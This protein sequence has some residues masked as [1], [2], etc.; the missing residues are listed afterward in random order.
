MQL[1]QS[2]LLMYY[3]LFTIGNN[4]NLVQLTV[5]DIIYNLLILSFISC[6]IYAQKIIKFHDLNTDFFFQINFCNNF[7]IGNKTV[8]N[9]VC[10]T[11]W[12]G[13]FMQ[14]IYVFLYFEFV[15]N[16]HFFSIAQIKI[17]L[18]FVCWKIARKASKCQER[19]P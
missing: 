18:D 2:A 16:I 4:S 19:L 1:V 5:L 10:N 17:S 14:I 3:R 15:F 9:M 11:I 6:I 8:S 13:V 12:A 7:N